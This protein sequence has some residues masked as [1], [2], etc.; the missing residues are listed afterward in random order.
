MEIY[1]F[2]RLSRWHGGLSLPVLVKLSCPG[3]DTWY[4]TNDKQDIHWD[5]HLYLSAGMNFQLPSS[6]DGVPSGGTLE[7]DVDI[8]NINGDELLKWFDLADD[9][10]EMEVVAIVNERGAINRVGQFR[11]R[12]GSV[13]WDGKKILW[14]AG[15]DDRLPMQINPWIF[16]SDGLSG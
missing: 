16:D 12:H 14:N 4:F 9:R 5:N 8:Q 2:F 15:G 10:A 1:D 13:S 11:Q 3:L 6:K 7:I